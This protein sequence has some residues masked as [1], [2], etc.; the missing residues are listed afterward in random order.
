MLKVAEHQAGR[1]RVDDRA[2]QA[3]QDDAHK[4]QRV[5]S[6]GRVLGPPEHD[7]ELLAQIWSDDLEAGHPARV[8]GRRMRLQLPGQDH[9]V[10]AAFQRA[11]SRQPRLGW[12]TVGQELGRLVGIGGRLA[13]AWPRS[14][15]A[16]S[17]T[18]NLASANSPAELNHKLK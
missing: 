6:A 11:A 18:G 9:P 14:L 2:A 12:V 1:D 7:P 13:S 16:T 3:G 10:P 4:P 17:V 15:T 5:T 8:L